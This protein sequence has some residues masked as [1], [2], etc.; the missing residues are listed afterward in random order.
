MRDEDQKL[1]F[2]VLTTGSI[3]R[4]GKSGSACGKTPHSTTQLAPCTPG[5]PSGSTGLRAGG[6]GAVVLR[7]GGDLAQVETFYSPQKGPGNCT[8]P[9]SSALGLKHWP[10]H[11]FLAAPQYRWSETPG[12]GG[13]V[14][15]D[16]SCS[17]LGNLGDLSQFCATF[18]VVSPGRPWAARRGSQPPGGI[19]WGP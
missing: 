15:V 11:L 19:N 1:L 18:T 12:G 4:Y 9:L 2:Q 6:R 7:K 13:V 16:G 3:I 17:A 5:K 8:R 10:C 14:G